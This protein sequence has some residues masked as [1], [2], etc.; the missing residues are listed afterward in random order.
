VF[1][2]LVSQARVV[3]LFDEI[4]RLLL[5]RESE[6]YEGQGDM[7]QF[8][9]PSMLTKINTLRRTRRSIFV[10]A[11]NYAERI[12]GAIKRPGRI[13]IQI[14]LLPPNLAQRR[15]FLR[16][17]VEDPKE[18]IGLT[19]TAEDYDLLAKSTPLFTFTELEHLV[20]SCSVDSAT[21]IEER[22]GPAVLE[23]PASITLVGYRSRF[24]TNKGDLLRDMSR[25]P[26]K[27]FALLVY[28]QAEVDERPIAEWGMGE[29]AKDVLQNRAPQ[30]LM[31]ELDEP[32]RD[33]LKEL[34][35]TV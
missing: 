1:D 10:I 14:P 6:R 32:V 25:G 29:W 21:P 23:Q 7:F 16:D 20:R 8:M 33:K 24:E 27:E 17:F 31:D 18:N 15:K 4:D 12:D 9:T 19:L 28:L 2:V 35:A 30:Q 5:D 34:F 3:I 22:I 11:T 26:W 13:D